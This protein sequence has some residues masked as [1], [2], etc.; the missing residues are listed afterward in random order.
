[1]INDAL[2][3]GNIP[4]CHAF[5][6]QSWGDWGPQFHTPKT[7]TMADSTQDMDVFNSSPYPL[8]VRGEEEQQTN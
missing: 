6:K 7:K 4:I 5:K 3:G 8:Q 1:M 2:K